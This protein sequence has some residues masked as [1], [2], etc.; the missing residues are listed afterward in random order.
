VKTK[1]TTPTP[2][3]SVLRE[4]QLRRSGRPL[5]SKNNDPE[6]AALR[7]RIIEL[8]RAG[9]S[10]HEI[11]AEVGRSKSYVGLALFRA[12]VSLIVGAVALQTTAPSSGGSR[13]SE[14]EDEEERREEDRQVGQG[15]GQGDSDEQGHEEGREEVSEDRRARQGAEEEGAGR[16]G[17]RDVTSSRAVQKKGAARRVLTARIVGLAHAGRSLREIAADVGLSVKGVGSQ[18]LRAGISLRELRASLEVSRDVIAVREMQARWHGTTLA[19]RLGLERDPEGVLEAEAVKLGPFVWQ[20]FRDRIDKLE[21]EVA[22]LRLEAASR[23][24]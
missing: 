17:R 8:A 16:A 14:E 20:H 12:G 9:R 10:G 7:A 22:T 23:P 1:T 3:S 4:E 18:L 11:A 13:G 21:A 15:E 24:R 6:L 19:A 5:G 2:A